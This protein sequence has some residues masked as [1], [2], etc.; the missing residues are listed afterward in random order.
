[1]NNYTT[2]ST[3]K[4][5]RV[6]TDILRQRCVDFAA[7]AVIAVMMVAGVFMAGMAI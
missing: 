7:W 3:G 6:H 2:T 5:Y 4:L 1:M